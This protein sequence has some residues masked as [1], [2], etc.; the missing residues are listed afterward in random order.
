MDDSKLSELRLIHQDLAKY[1][2]DQHEA[3]SNSILAVAAIRE[4]LRQN[5]ALQ[6]SYEESLRDLKA[7]GTIQPT[8]ALEQTLLSLLERLA[9]W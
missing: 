8:P 9:E 7:D 6:K 1:L 4:V 3:M 2:K 5:P